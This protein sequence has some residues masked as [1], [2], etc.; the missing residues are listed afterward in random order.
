M[1]SGDSSNNPRSFGAALDGLEAQ[2]GGPWILA[3]TALGL[4]AFGAFS[5][6]EARFRR[7]K[8]PRGLNPLT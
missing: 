3:L 4:I 7:I 6:I 2:P 5:F 1:P 8:P